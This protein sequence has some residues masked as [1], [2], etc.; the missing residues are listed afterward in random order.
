MESG[1]HTAGFDE[2]AV[3]GVTPEIGLV[4][5]RGSQREAKLEFIEKWDCGK[6]V[7]R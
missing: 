1:M 4:G 6:C 5:V 7:Q 2:A 3:F